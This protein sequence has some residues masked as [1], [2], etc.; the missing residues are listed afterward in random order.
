MMC[1]KGSSMSLTDCADD[2]SVAR[3][4]RLRV[5]VQQTHVL[6]ECVCHGSMELLGVDDGGGHILCLRHDWVCVCRKR[7]VKTEK[8]VHR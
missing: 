6:N 8:K 4:S 5:D 2:A 7:P 3:H 1:I